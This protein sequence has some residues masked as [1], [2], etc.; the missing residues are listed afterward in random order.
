[1]G[2][3]SLLYTNLTGLV[4]ILQTQRQRMPMRIVPADLFWCVGAYKRVQPD[5]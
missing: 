3:V 5:I 1:M 2:R 4:F